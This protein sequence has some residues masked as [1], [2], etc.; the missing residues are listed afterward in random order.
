MGRLKLR[1]ATHRRSR[2]M[3]GGSRYNL[4]P[5]KGGTTTGEE[6]RRM[7]SASR[8]RSVISARL[9]R[10]RKKVTMRSLRGHGLPT[11]PDDARLPPGPGDP[12]K[13]RK[14]CTPQLMLNLLGTD[15]V[16]SDFIKCLGAQAKVDPDGTRC[17]PRGAEIGVCQEHNHWVV[18]TKKGEIDSM[19]QW[20]FQQ[21]PG[22]G[23]CQTYAALNAAI[24]QACQTKDHSTQTGQE[25]FRQVAGDWG[26]DIGDPPPEF[27]QA[28]I[29]TVLNYMPIAR[30]HT[31][32]KA[33]YRY[34][35][36]QRNVDLET[37]FNIANE[38]WDTWPETAA[39]QPAW[40]A[41]KQDQRDY[42][43]KRL[44]RNMS[45]ASR[46]WRQYFH[47]VVAHDESSMCAPE[48]NEDDIL[49][50]LIEQ[51][52]IGG[53]VDDILS[54]RPQTDREKDEDMDPRIGPHDEA[55]RPWPG[56]A[57]EDIRNMRDAGDSPATI[58]LQLAGESFSRIIGL[59]GDLAKDDNQVIDLSDADCMPTAIADADV[60]EQA[61][62][63]GRD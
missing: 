44:A 57:A 54:R 11:L 41:Y 4:R 5:L 10:P 52:G 51:C 58:K 43:G 59:L 15:A 45:A 21:Y 2:P 61:L 36:L 22:H 13:S 39:A 24:L 23:L 49:R 31:D 29:K 8:R 1:R 38:V 40:E 28:F 34:K 50:I 32:Q 35:L 56:W 16:L 27:K 17:A 14:G 33:Y 19:N 37:K 25:E 12:E 30:L 60:R 42:L 47:A 3:R 9:R 63:Y 18:R 62:L 55:K 26:L 20:L 48:L 46:Y 7:T 6:R 53:V